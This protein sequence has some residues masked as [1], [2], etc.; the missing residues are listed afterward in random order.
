MRRVGRLARTYQEWRACL[1]ML[2]Q[3]SLADSMRQLNLRI[4]RYVLLDA[5]PL[6]GVQSHRFAALPRE[7]CVREGLEDQNECYEILLP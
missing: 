3:T 7:R 1:V 5:D 4:V 6:F 2:H